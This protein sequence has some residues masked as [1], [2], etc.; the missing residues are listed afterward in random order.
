MALAK[1]CLFISLLFYISSLT[2]TAN[3][4]RRCE[5]STRSNGEMAM[6]NRGIKGHS[7]KNYTLSNAYDCHVKC[8]LERCKCQAFQMKQ[9][10]CELLDEDRFSSP[11]DFLEEEGYLYHD[12]NREYDDQ[13]TNE[14]CLLIPVKMKKI[15]LKLK[16]RSFL[17]FLPS[18]TVIKELLF[19]N[20]VEVKTND[21]ILPFH[22]YRRWWW[23][24]RRHRSYRVLKF[25][26]W[27][28]FVRVFIFSLR[29]RQSYYFLIQF[30]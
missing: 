28:A 11:E 25:R 12:M 17:T 1:Y 4:Q 18:S 22:I 3:C 8:F 23:S 16:I 2:S 15:E 10:L 5:L 26:G 19:S 30:F 14:S 24:T 7:F 20:S 21:C 27:N 13:V 6:K 29:I 9:N